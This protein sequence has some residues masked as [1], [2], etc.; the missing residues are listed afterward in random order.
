MSV[1][2]FFRWYDLWVGAYLDVENKAIYICPV[3]T[4]GVRIGWSK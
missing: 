2:F 4:L 3:P 1:R